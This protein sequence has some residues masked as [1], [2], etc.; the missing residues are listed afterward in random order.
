MSIVVNQK[1]AIIG[2]KRIGDAIYTLPLIEALK[3]QSRAAEITLFTESQVAAIYQENPTIDKLVVLDKADFWWDTLSALK[4]GQFDICIVLHN[5]FKY[6]L[7]PYLA[8]VPVRVGYVKEAR[9]WMLTHKLPLSNRVIH[10]L[11][12]NA[13]LGDLLGVN[14]RGL[15]PQIH[16]EEDAEKSQAL[17]KHLGLVAGGY[18]VMVV[19]SISPTR[20][21]FYDRFAAVV[22]R[23]AVELKL[24]VIIVGGSDDVEAG[25]IVMHLSGNFARNLAGRTSLRETIWLMRS[26]KA[27]VTNDTGPMHVA[28]AIGIP[29]VTWFGAANEAEIAP[30]SP[31]TTI[32]NAHVACSPC[33]K[34]SCHHDLIC[35]KAI[36]PD[37]VMAALKHK[38]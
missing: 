21:W 38:L 13:R 14:A 1:I 12:H 7:L 11:E 28:S 4:V 30:P 26:A 23:I 2:L 10:R 34:E 31:N 8:Y 20:R 17:L 27:V 18:V 6:A 5:A 15:L 9:G 16:F 37:M 25:E 24:T 3:Q 19:G 32:L 33:V 29:V 22:K 36:T 35:L